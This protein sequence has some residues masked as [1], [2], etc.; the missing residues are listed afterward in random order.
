MF[1]SN[2]ES[3]GEILKFMVCQV[4]DVT[5]VTDDTFSSELPKA[6]KGPAVTSLDEIWPAFLW[7]TKFVHR[8]EQ[9][10]EDHFRYFT[11]L[12]LGA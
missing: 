4:S 1:I 6:P 9:T 3:K 11:S 8:G 5:N 10:C 7:I 2:N 12:E